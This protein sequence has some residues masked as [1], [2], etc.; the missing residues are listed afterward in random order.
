[1]TYLSMRPNTLLKKPVLRQMLFLAIAL[2]LA[3]N[4][5]ALQMKEMIQDQRLQFKISL[6]DL[7]RIEVRGD[8]INQVFGNGGAFVVDHDSDKGHLYIKPSPTNGRRP[9]SLSITTE[10]GDVQDLILTPFDMPSE[11]VLLKSAY[12]APTKQGKH[13]LLG[14][15]KDLVQGVVQSKY[16]VD[17]GVEEMPLWDSIETKRITTY[18]SG[19]LY[20]EILSFKNEGEEPVALHETHF[21]TMGEET[22]TVLAIGLEK[23]EVGPGE[24]TKVYRVMKRRNQQDATLFRGSLDTSNSPREDSNAREVSHV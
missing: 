21:I 1:M 11:T 17:H 16:E 7:N 19:D 8:R 18:K 6:Y 12:R 9:I 2:F 14:F 24:G 23:Y 5:A 13:I 20:G 22:N 4:A 10:N 15:M 3:T